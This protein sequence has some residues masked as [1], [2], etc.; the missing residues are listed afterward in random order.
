MF[1]SDMGKDSSN[2]IGR[3]LA[4]IEVS[5]CRSLNP[6]D[7]FKE[8]LEDSPSGLWRWLGKS[9]GSNPSRVQIPYPPPNS[10]D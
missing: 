6:F 10:F 5:N 1:L 2:K 7:K 8:L 3:L 4:F 9:V